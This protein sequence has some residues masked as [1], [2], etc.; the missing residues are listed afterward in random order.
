MRKMV[1]QPW[2][3]A[4]LSTI[5]S[6]AYGFRL[7][8]STAIKSTSGLS[9]RYLAVSMSASS[10]KAKKVLVLGGDGF[11]GWPTSLYLSEEGHDVVIVD[12][13]SRRKIDLELGC[14]SLTP[15]A[16]AEQRIKV[17]NDVS[18][19]NGRG[20][21]LRFKYL[22]LHQD[23]TELVQF[24]L[25]EKPDTV[26]HFAEQRAAPYSMKEPRTKRY[27]IDN[28]VQGTHNLLCAIVESGW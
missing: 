13:L 14:D 8:S 26:V 28:N 4:V 18:N 20:Q 19:A 11:C 27:T 1:L 22:D 9:S 24:L 7:Y 3:I 23:Y 10:P 12:N 17:W 16:T 21:K 15:I 2:L 25:N 6:K 5:L